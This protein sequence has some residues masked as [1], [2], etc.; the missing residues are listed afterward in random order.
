MLEDELTR[1]EEYTSCRF[2]AVESDVQRIDMEL[3]TCVKE[4]DIQWI[5]KTT[6]TD[7]ENTAKQIESIEVKE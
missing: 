6:K 4:K 7:K 3:E 2:T 5:E 1:P